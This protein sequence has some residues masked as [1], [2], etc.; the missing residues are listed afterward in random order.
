MSNDYIS[1]SD[2]ETFATIDEAFKR[3]F[4]SK[5]PQLMKGCFDPLP[6]FK[7]TEI[8]GCH[9]WFPKLKPNDTGWVTQ[10]IDNGNEITSKNDSEKGKAEIG[11][12]NVAFAHMGK[13]YVFVGIFEL[14]YKDPDG[15]EHWKKI[16]D[17]CP[18][19]STQNKLS[20][21]AMLCLLF[22]AILTASPC[23]ADVFE[24]FKKSLFCGDAVCSEY[25]SYIFSQCI[26]RV[27]SDC[28]KKLSDEKK[29]KPN[30]LK[31]CGLEGS[32]KCKKTIDETM[33]DS[34]GIEKIPGI[35][36][37]FYIAADSLSKLEEEKS[38]VYKDSDM[39]KAKK[40]KQLEL[41][42]KKEEKFG[43]EM[44]K[45]IQKQIINSPI[46]LKG[47]YVHDFAEAFFGSFPGKKETDQI[48]KYNDN[49]NYSWLCPIGRYNKSLFEATIFVDEKF[50]EEA[51]RGIYD[52]TGTIVDFI[53][54]K[55]D[56]YGYV[57]FVLHI[58]LKSTKYVGKK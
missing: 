38:K 22:L 11:Q 2:S 46:T 20:A 8:E 6:S 49:G 23:Y 15:T 57:R 32:K 16:G 54:D 50:A 53:T 48:I 17:K 44:L 5:N 19:I 30:K 9:I 33:A 31:L 18:I 51:D 29:D 4:S 52:I 25:K 42:K 37:F 36:S 10:L 3:V 14:K 13:G 7:G 41:L 34:G 1:V 43:D 47:I 26:K 28:E 55:E 12:K 27:D 56:E 58:R 39:M 24:D 45:I 21:A 35:K 40:E